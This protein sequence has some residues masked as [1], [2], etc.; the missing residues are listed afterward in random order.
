[1]EIVV[2]V[3]EVEDGHI[4]IRDVRQWCTSNVD[5][6]SDAMDALKDWNISAI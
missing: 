4:V 5:D 6:A 1:M 3:L 2:C